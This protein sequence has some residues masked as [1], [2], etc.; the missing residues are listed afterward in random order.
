MVLATLPTPAPIHTMSSVCLLSVINFNQ[1]VSLIREMRNVET[2]E[3]SWR[4][5]NNNVVI[6][7]SQGL[8][9]FLKGYR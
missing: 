9:I 3:N 8:K 7:H 1:R 6:K 5:L 4:R 2:K